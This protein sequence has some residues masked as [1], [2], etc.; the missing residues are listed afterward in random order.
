MVQ[1]AVQRVL[2][3]GLLKKTFRFVF[4]LVRWITLSI[5]GSDVS[6]SVGS[7]GTTLKSYDIIESVEGE[8]C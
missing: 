6:M 7:K 3:K 4:V 2:K 5:T 8:I 1:K